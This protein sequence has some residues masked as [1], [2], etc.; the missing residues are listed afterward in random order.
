MAYGKIFRFIFDSQN[1]SEIEIYILKK[2]YL[3][4][5]ITRP[6]GR[7]PILKRDS[8]NC[9]YGTSLE[10]YAECKVD[11]EYATLYT[12]SADEYKV[13][14]Y[15]NKELVW[16]GFVSP[17][18]YSEPDTAPPYD[19]QIIAT[20]GLGELKNTTFNTH[21]RK[22]ISEH[23][24]YILSQTK[25]SLSLEILST[26][27]AG[28]FDAMSSIIDIDNMAD[29]TCYDVLQQLLSSL[30]ATITQNGASWLMMRETDV[31]HKVSTAGLEVE[32]FSGSSKK[33]PISQFGSVKQTDWWPVGVLST[34]IQPAY[35]KLSLKS[36]LNYRSLFEDSWTFENSGKYDSEK[37]AYVL[38]Y[39]KSA[40]YQKVLAVNTFKR[41]LEI[42]LGLTVTS[43]NTLRYSGA[44]IAFYITRKYNDVLYYLV[45]NESDEYI[46][47]ENKE[48]IKLPIKYNDV[49][50][51]LQNLTVAIPLSE[52]SPAD[53]IG[54]TVINRFDGL[55]DSELITYT[56]DI[57]IY[58]IALLP[59]SRLE[60]F[61]TNAK[62][63]NGARNKY[64]EIVTI[65]QPSSIFLTTPDP[66]KSIY[67]VP[68]SPRT[69][70]YVSSWGRF[71]AAQLSYTTMIAQDYAESISLPRMEITG[72][73]NVPIGGRL[74]MVFLKD[75]T[76]YILQRYS[77]NLIN[78]ELEVLLVS[79]PN[80]SVEVEEVIDKPIS[81]SGG[82]TTSSSPGSS[83]GG[84]GSSTIILD[85]EMSD[86]STNA[87]EN[88][89]I[90]AYVD[91]ENSRQDE[92]I[93]T[94]IQSVLEQGATLAAMWKLS[95]DG[96]KVVTNKQVV[97]G[98]S[99]LGSLAFKNSL[100]ASDISDL[101]STYLPKSGGELTKS[102][103]EILRVSANGANYATIAFRNKP[104]GAS[105]YNSAA[106]LGYNGTSGEWFVTDGGWSV[107]N[108][109]Y[110]TGNFN[111]ADYLPLIGGA[112]SGDFKV[113]GTTTLQTVKIWNGGNT[114]AEIKIDG[115]SLSINKELKLTN[116]GS[117]DISSS[118][119]AAF[120][121]DIAQIKSLIAND[122]YIGASSGTTSNLAF[123]VNTYQGVS[124]KRPNLKQTVFSVD[125]LGNATLIGGLTSNTL[126]A[127]YF[128]KSDE[129]YFGSG[130]MGVGANGALIYTY[131]NLPIYFYTSGSLAMTIDSGHGV[132]MESGLH[133]KGI[134][135][136]N[137]T[138]HVGSTYSED[139]QSGTS[140]V[141]IRNEGGIE[142]SHASTPY[143]DFHYANATGDYSV[144][145]AAKSSSALS[146]RG[147]ISA[148]YNNGYN[149]GTSDVRWKKLWATD[150]NFAGNLEV[151]GTTT[152][153]SDMSVWGR[154]GV[155]GKATFSEAIFEKDVEIDGNLVVYGD[156]ATL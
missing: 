125:T 20:D 147:N 54:V 19:V 41:S 60:G 111:P 8:N 10:L 151:G 89:T 17:E 18:L 15:K 77:Y 100:A 39:N 30:H 62:I 102:G 112:I 11:S 155:I 14:L 84:S 23:L 68:I 59:Y 43:S 116:G 70:N 150:G 45:A 143:I 85:T 66:Q 80:A 94:I 55:Y 131:N 51:D 90:K 140:G 103:S 79:V 87:V 24:V 98:T 149:L 145:M 12:S 76:Y 69:N 141:T 26:L 153:N 115:S 105:S 6:L 110:H 92:S 13:E 61:E 83:G 46:W 56:A 50:D 29:M 33:I 78:D 126:A 91:S 4:N 22:S 96:T 36:Q 53:E 132:T 58:T 81:T 48:L 148:W 144:R 142:I 138:L 65:F 122:V 128:I 117:A 107:T 2:N 154:M 34:K 109:L 99:P 134:G 37:Q 101:S 3:G 121:T 28:G 156:V 31:R 16:V 49:S 47:T 73:I 130:A 113:N 67:A 72:T 86:T 120:K 139:G 71:E 44:A 129:F 5:I 42:Q 133:V 21:G 104:S 38:S 146:F 137:G 64:N 7:A 82:T 35:N 114:V 127:N 106:W 32:V 75:N 1:G 123:N 119:A 93:T 52:T 40:M 124:N 118:I 88:K 25:L 108:I 152:F 63:R 57:N 9:I 95:D 74:P 136:I 97:V 27:T 135:L